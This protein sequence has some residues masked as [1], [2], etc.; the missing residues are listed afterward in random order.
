V[1]LLLALVGIFSVTAFAVTRRAP[2]IGVR[3]ALGARP[4]V[5]VRTILGD[6]TWPILAGLAAGIGGSFLASRLVT[7]FLYQT[8]PNDV[9]AFAAS[10]TVLGAASLV[11]AWLPARKAAR[12]DPVSAMRAE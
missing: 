4:A 9:I 7:A 1:G 8:S 2:E 12:I 11:A 10:A 3:M 6:T 5:V